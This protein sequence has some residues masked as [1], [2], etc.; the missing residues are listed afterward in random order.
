MT[1]QTQAPEPT[2]ADIVL[3][4][5]VATRV[6]NMITEAALLAQTLGTEITLTQILGAVLSHG[7]QISD[8]P[9]TREQFVAVYDRVQEMFVVQAAR[10]AAAQAVAQAAAAS[11]AGPEETADAASAQEADTLAEKWGQRISDV[12][13]GMPELGEQ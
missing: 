9:I 4:H 5:N 2:G 12:A 13:F 8:P 6:Q 11:G 7:Q 3:A 10:Q 1:E